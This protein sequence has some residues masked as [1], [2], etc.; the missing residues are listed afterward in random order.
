MDPKQNE[1]TGAGVCGHGTRKRFNFSL[2]LYTPVFQ[3]GVLVFQ[4]V[5]S[6]KLN[7]VKIETF[8]LYQI[9]CNRST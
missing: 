2:G 6:R 1:G 5:Q 9:D 8:I 7:A 3:A 4:Y